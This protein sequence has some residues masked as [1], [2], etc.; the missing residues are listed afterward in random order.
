MFQK[1]RTNRLQTKCQ[2]RRSIHDDVDPQKFECGKRCTETGKN[3]TDNNYYRRNINGQLELNETFEI[4]IDSTSPLHRFDDCGERIIQKYHITGFLC[5]ICSGDTHGNADIYNCCRR[6]TKNRDLFA[7][8]IKF[9]LQ[10]SRCFFNRRKFLCD[11]AKLCIV[12]YTGNQ[13]LSISC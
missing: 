10:R 7:K 13:H 1:I 2:C 3:R 5:G 9:F 4:L 11:L 12:S 6:S 8:F